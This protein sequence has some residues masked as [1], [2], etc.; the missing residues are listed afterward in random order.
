VLCGFGWAGEVRRIR[1][2]GWSWGRESNNQN[3]QYIKQS[4]FN[5]K[6][7]RCC[8]FSGKSYVCVCVCVC[9]CVFVC[10]RAGCCCCCWWWRVTFPRNSK[11]QEGKVLKLVIVTLKRLSHVLPTDPKQNKV[12]NGSASMVKIIGGGHNML[13][14]VGRVTSWICQGVPSGRRRRGQGGG[15]HGRGGGGG[16]GKQHYELATETSKATFYPGNQSFHNSEVVAGKFLR[17]GPSP[18]HLSLFFH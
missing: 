9:V 4:N 3:I 11:D 8:L 14:Q 15:G 12:T 10:A 1:V 7:I 2:D 16:G 5:K 17:R 18:A 13:K 6:K